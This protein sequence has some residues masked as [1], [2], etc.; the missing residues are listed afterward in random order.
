MGNNVWCVESMGTE[1]LASSMLS[2][3]AIRGEESDTENIIRLCKT[4]KFWSADT[5]TKEATLSKYFNMD[6]L[7]GEFTAQT[8]PSRYLRTYCA[9]EKTWERP[10]WKPEFAI[11]PWK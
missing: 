1:S 7:F 3:L 9:V 8:L 2:A 4:K 11:K 6:K 10:A 5:G